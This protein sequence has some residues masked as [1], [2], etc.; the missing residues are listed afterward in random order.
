VNTQEIK[1]TGMT[2]TQIDDFDTPTETDM[3]EAEYNFVQLDTDLANTAVCGAELESRNMI[4]H[5]LRK[6]GSVLFL[7]HKFGS[8]PRHYGISNAISVSKV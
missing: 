1:C 2:I 6:K 5:N 4:C 7:K 8:S 3:M